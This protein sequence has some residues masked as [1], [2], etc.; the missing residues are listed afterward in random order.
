MVGTSGSAFE[1]CTPNKASAR[2]LPALIWERHAEIDET[3]TCELLPRN[4]V[5]AGPPPWVGKC[6]SFRSP[7]AA[8]DRAVGGGEQ[9][10]RDVQRAVEARGAEDDFVRPFL[11]VIDQVFETLVGLLIID[12]QDSRSGYQGRDRDEVGAGELWRASEEFVDFGKTGDRGEVEKQRI[13]VGLG[14]GDVLRA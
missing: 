13:A 5:S 11:G 9:R 3:S 1:R 8:G 6:L 10:G 7:A 12:D 14:I 2:A 4:A